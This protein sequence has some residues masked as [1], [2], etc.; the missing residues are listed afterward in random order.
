MGP[1]RS[2][3][4]GSELGNDHMFPASYFFTKSSSLIYIKSFQ[5]A[6]DSSFIFCMAIK[7]TILG[8]FITW[9]TQSGVRRQLHTGSNTYDIRTNV[10]PNFIYRHSFVSVIMCPMYSRF[11]SNCSTIMFHV[12][13]MKARLYSMHKDMVGNL[14]YQHASLM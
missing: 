10:T 11:I 1:H 9:T 6:Q 5:G 8:M 14:E 7:L 2:I 13:N 4:S 3:K 12:F